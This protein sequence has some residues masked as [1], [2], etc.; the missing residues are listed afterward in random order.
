[1]L[2]SYTGSSTWSSETTERGRMGC[3]LGGRFQRKRNMDTYGGFMLRYGRNQHN[4][5]KQ[6]SSN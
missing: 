4:T 2:L 3:R 5:A 1:M 6:L